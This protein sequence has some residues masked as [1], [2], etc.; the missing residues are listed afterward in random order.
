MTEK[1]KRPE[2]VGLLLRVWF[3][4]G[5]GELVHQIL[6][7]TLS[8]LNRD[9]LVAALRASMKDQVDYPEALLDVSANIAIFG[10]ALMFM[11]VIGLL[12]FMLTRIAKQHK[13][14]GTARRMWFAFSLFF[15]FR[16]LLV[17]LTQPAGSDAPD[18]L[19]ALDGVVQILVGVGAAMALVFS[20]REETLEFTGEM[21]QIR[22]LEAEQKQKRDREDKGD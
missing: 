10:S 16:V 8:Y 11:A 5:V 3:L 6:Q 20:L 18:W 15:V 4:V 9:A 2:S 21:E 19:F 1:T 12:M 17:F 7:I 14:A 13:W 22:Q